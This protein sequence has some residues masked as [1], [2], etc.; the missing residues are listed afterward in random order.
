MAPLSASTV[1]EHLPNATPVRAPADY[2]QVAMWVTFLPIV[3]VHVLFMFTFPLNSR[4]GDTPNYF[5]MLVKGD[6]SLVHPSGYP[7]L[8]GLPFRHQPMSSLAS[9]DKADLEHVL[10]IAQHGIAIVSMVALFVLVRRIYGSVTASVGTLILGMN[11]TF[12]GAMSAT[13]PEWMQASLLILS[14]WAAGCAYFHAG[15]RGKVLWY[16]LSAVLFSWCFLTKFNASVLVV[17]YALP[18]AAER[19]PWRQKLLWTGICALL[20]VVTVLTYEVTFQQPRAGTRRLTADS[21]WVLLTRIQTAYAN[22]LDA[23][24]GLATKRWLALAAA[25]PLQYDV[26]GPGLFR[27]VDAVPRAVRAP[28]RPLFDR[29]VKAND[30]FLDD[31]L[32][33]H[34]VPSGFTVGVSPIPVCY[35]VGLFECNDLGVKVAIE[36][37]RAAP[38]T[39]AKTVWRD[40]LE[41]AS[42]FPQSALSPTVANMR[43]FHFTVNRRLSNGFVLLNPSS[44][45]AHAVP[46]SYR[47]P[48]VWWPGLQWFEWMN[49]LPGLEMLTRMLVATAII[50]AV[51]SVLAR[52]RVSME[53]GVVL[54]VSGA[55]TIFIIASCMTLAFR[56][57]EFCLALPLISLLAGAGIGWAP[58]EAVALARDFRRA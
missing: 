48:V 37:V 43:L 2:G 8:I 53:A 44:S 28:Y 23:S 41:A 51:V 58:R 15:G 36:A 30:A 35:Y 52:R 6:A 27:H 18:L 34:P 26:A 5:T 13:Y 45:P 17:L 1:S 3:V 55:L 56:W 20:V 50:I 9:G 46:Y 32:R 38:I 11:I 33:S 42:A 57:K 22:Q 21:S 10:L 31:W 24:N 16:L 19:R 25:L 14:G 47:F 54:V 7:F 49:N 12:M 4:G 39:F 29:L 40:F